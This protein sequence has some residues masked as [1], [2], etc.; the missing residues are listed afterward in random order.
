MISAMGNTVN[1]TSDTFCIVDEG[2]SESEYMPLE[3]TIKNETQR[4]KILKMKIDLVS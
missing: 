4:E 2:I 3:T 1:G